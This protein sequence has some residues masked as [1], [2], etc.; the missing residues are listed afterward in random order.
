M[1]RII[2][3]LALAVAAITPAFAQ[4]NT[5][6]R[7]D[8]RVLACTPRVLKK[9]GSVTL[10]LGPRHGAEMA[11]RRT[12]TRDWYYV[13]T[14]GPE[15]Q[16]FMTPKAFAAAR[17]VTLNEYTQG[18]GPPK[19]NL[20]KIFTRPGRYAVYISDKLESDAGGNVCSI[21]YSG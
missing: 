2:L 18:Y 5:E 16:P 14:G 10:A 4:D 1:R 13:V 21:I 12:G 3:V 20:V 17:R 8:N 9:G 11:V 6:W 7:D 15:P 19:G